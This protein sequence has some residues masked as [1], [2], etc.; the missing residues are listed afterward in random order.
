[1]DH[2]SAIQRRNSLLMKAALIA[3]CAFLKISCTPIPMEGNGPL[4]RAAL[5]TGPVFRVPYGLR[6]AVHIPTI[7]DARQ[8]FTM[9]HVSNDV[10]G[11]YNITSLLPHKF[12]ILLY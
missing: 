2:F 5:L 6:W 1:M 8:S 7:T 9:S 3:I 10:S 11:N 12:L 4:H